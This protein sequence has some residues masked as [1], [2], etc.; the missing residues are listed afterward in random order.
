[1]AAAGSRFFPAW[2]AP[3]NAFVRR[4]NAPYVTNF[5]GM[6]RP[7]RHLADYVPGLRVKPALWGAAYIAWGRYKGS[8]SVFGRVEFHRSDS[9]G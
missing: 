5:E 6:R 9:P 4:I 8:D 1:M 7:W 3:A 2:L